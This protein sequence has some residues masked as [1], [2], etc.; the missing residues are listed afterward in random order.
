[1][2]IP[3]PSLKIVGTIL[4]RDEEDIIATNIEHHINQGITQFIVTDNGSVDRT[5]SIAESYPEVKEI[6]DE[7]G[8]DHRQSEWVTRMARLACKMDADWIVHLDAD[9][10]WCGFS[11]LRRITAAAAGCTVMYL[12]PPTKG[13]FS[14]S[15]MR[16]YL[17]FENMGLPGECKIVHRPDP[18][19]VITHGNHGCNLETQYTKDIWRHHYP[20]RSFEQF[21]RKAVNGHKALASRNAICDRWEKWNDLQEQGELLCLYERVC[22]AWNEM[23]LQSTTEQLVSML[24]FWS[25]SEVVDFFKSSGLLPDIG[26]WPKSI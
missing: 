7:A 9:E 19:V 23:Q 20:V 12:H 26:E 11:G 22:I 24:E 14:L 3:N 18:N 5:R 6:I 2:I 16:H 21:A 4:A 8:R 10:L 1:M 25:T 17:D 15:N 13:S